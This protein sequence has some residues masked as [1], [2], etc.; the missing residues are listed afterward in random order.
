MFLWQKF[1][2][3]NVLLNK[4]LKSWFHE[5]FFSKWEFLIFPHEVLH[6]QSE[7]TKN[8]ETEYAICLCKMFSWIFQKIEKPIFHSVLKLISRKNYLFFLL[9]FY[10]HGK[11]VACFTDFSINSMKFLHTIYTFIEFWFH[12]KFPKIFFF[13]FFRIMI[14]RPKSFVY[15]CINLNTSDIRFLEKSKNK[16][17]NQCEQQDMNETEM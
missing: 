1:R 8:D 13:L 10:S 2:E 7:F 14:L 11:K 4:L 17:W 9:F 15:F 16:C 12:E 6:V 3:S 5:I